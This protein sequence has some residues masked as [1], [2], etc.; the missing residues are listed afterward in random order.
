VRV[1]GATLNNFFGIQLTADN[2]ATVVSAASGSGAASGTSP[3]GSPFIDDTPQGSVL[4]PF[5]ENN[6]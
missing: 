6:I 2:F 3:V 5:A 1:E 4:P